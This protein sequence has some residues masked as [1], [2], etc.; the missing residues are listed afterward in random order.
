[1]IPF[2]DLIAGLLETCNWSDNGLTILI[3]ISFLVDKDIS[4]CSGAS[5]FHLHP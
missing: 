4:K 1:M 5:F 3:E 2:R